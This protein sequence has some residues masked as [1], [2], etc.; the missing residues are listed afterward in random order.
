ME[1]VAP[2][3]S[4]LEC[5]DEAVTRTVLRL[6]HSDLDECSESDDADDAGDEDGNHDPTEPAAEGI[7]CAPGSVASAGAGDGSAVGGASTLAPS[8]AACA[9]GLVRASRFR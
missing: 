9:S 5:R 1:L 3:E 6:Q 2:A 4:L 7:H 8:R